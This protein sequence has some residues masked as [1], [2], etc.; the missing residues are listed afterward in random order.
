MAITNHAAGQKYSFSH[1]ACFGLAGEGGTKG[2]R[3]SSRALYQNYI[4]F[5]NY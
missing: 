1:H 2:I 5:V 3:T 4:I